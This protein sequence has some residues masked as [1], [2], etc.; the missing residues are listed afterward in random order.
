VIEKKW[1]AGRDVPA[2]NSLGKNAMKVHPAAAI[3]PLLDGAMFDA[4]V[5]DVRANGLREPIKVWNGMLLDG[6]N[7][8]RAC[9]AAGIEPRYQELDFAD[10]CEAIAYIISE[11]I[12]RRHLDVGQRAMLGEALRPHLAAAAK[13]R[14]EAGQKRGRQSQGAARKG[15]DKVDGAEKSPIHSDTGKVNTQLADMLNVSADTMKK[16]HKVATHA[17]ELA[18]KVCNGEI[19][20]GA[21]YKAVKPQHRNP[22]I[23]PAKEQAAAQA[24]LDDGKSLARAA[25]EFGIGSPHV[26]KV[27]VARERGRRET[28]EKVDPTTL[29]MGAKEKLDTAIRQERRKLDVEFEQRVQAEIERAVN[30]TVLPQYTREMAEAR[31]IIEARKGIMPRD[32][33]RLILSCLHPDR[34]NDDESLKRRF[35]RAFQA[36]KERE[37][38]LCD[39]KEMPTTAPAI[40]RTYAEMMKRRAETKA[41]RTRK[42]NGVQMRPSSPR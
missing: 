36:F 9:E 34:V 24:V 38:L 11:N 2:C 35:A 16:A 23:T 29:S 10:E 8:E 37:L 31:Q 14:Q 5:D 41:R 1:D 39:E 33:Y 30:E 7:R 15:A 21:A 42:S 26:A 28:A 12:V 25:T 4:F 19:K 18:A 6:R 17:P 3:F 22:E 32:A 20:L 40:P 13:A 27:A